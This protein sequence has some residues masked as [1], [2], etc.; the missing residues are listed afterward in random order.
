MKTMVNIF[1]LWLLMSASVAWAQSKDKFDATSVKLVQ[2]E[3]GITNI[4]GRIIKLE[5]QIGKTEEV[6]GLRAELLELKNKISVIQADIDDAVIESSARLDDFS[7]Q[8][9]ELS[10]TQADLK[11]KIPDFAYR[12]TDLE[13]TLGPIADA[14]RVVTEDTSTSAKIFKITSLGPF[15]DELPISRDCQEVGGILS[16]YSDRSYNTVFVK[17]QTG[18]VELCTYELGRWQVLDGDEFSPGHVVKAE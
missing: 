13:E 10:N 6:E 3:N 9:I 16:R 7:S 17:S 15:L 18:S 14:G 11:L 1:C 12:L 8:L 5:N 4:L 2:M